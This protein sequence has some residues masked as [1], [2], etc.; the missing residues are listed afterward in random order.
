MASAVDLAYNNTQRMRPGP[1][2]RLSDRSFRI[3]R[4]DHRLMSLQWS[5]GYYT[6]Q[7]TV[8]FLAQ[9]GDTIWATD[10]EHIAW[11]QATLKQVNAPPFNVPDPRDSSRPPPVPKSHGE[12]IA[13]RIRGTTPITHDSHPGTYQDETPS[14]FA[15]VQLPPEGTQYFGIKK[16]HRKVVHPDVYTYT[17]IAGTFGTPIPSKKDPS[18]IRKVPSASPEHSKVPFCH[19]PHEPWAAGTPFGIPKGHYQPKSSPGDGPASF[20]GVPETTHRRNPH[21]SP[22]GSAGGRPPPPPPRGPPSGGP[23]DDLVGHPAVCHLL[24]VR[25]AHHGPL[26]HIVKTQAATILDPMADHQAE[27]L[28]GREQDS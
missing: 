21:A 3:F 8:G 2:S 5:A 22:R 4:T 1:H 23:P 9:E 28:L 14:R 26:L 25:D 12:S 24:V 16:G 7:G 11:I 15:N 6:P 13:R 10:E 19:T 18:P 17:N 27:D 20:F